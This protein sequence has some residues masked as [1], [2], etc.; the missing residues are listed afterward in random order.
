M[1][2]P[3]AACYST[4]FYDVLDRKEDAARS[5]VATQEVL[6]PWQSIRSP[7]CERARGVATFHR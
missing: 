7:A 3:A 4:L 5:Q 6:A 2:T 1:A